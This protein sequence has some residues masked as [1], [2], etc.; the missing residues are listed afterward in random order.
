MKF[1][2]TSRRAFLKSLGLAIGGFALSSCGSGGSDGV[3]NGL[4]GNPILFPGGY[5][6]SRFVREGDHLPGGGVIADF[7][8]AVVIHDNSEVVFAAEDETGNQ[9][10]YR[11]YFDRAAFAPQRA[12][13]IRKVLRQGDVLPDGR[14]VERI[15]R[16]A[17]NLHHS[18]AVI[19]QTSHPTE[20]EELIGMQSRIYFSE[21]MG[22]FLPLLEPF[23][24]LP[25]GTGR[26]G[27]NFGDLDLH[28]N[29][30]LLVT[31][32]YSDDTAFPREGLFFI[33]GAHHPS[34]SKLFSNR[35]LVPDADGIIAGIGLIDL[36]DD[37]NFV[38]QVRTE[39]PA[40]LRG[41]G[42]GGN[43]P[44][45]VV[46]G[47]ARDLGSISLRGAPEGLDV[48]P[49]VR[50]RGGFLEGDSIYGPRVG[51]DGK[52]AQIV[53]LNDDDLVLAVGEQELFRAGGTV[54]SDEV[55]SM[56]GPVLG[57]NGLLYICLHSEERQDLVASDG[58]AFRTYL[59]QDD[60][61]DGLT[62]DSIGFGFMPKQVD[63]DGIMAFYG[64]FSDNTAAV[65]L[66]LPT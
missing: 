24:D 37:S 42:R 65:V 23:T 35:D 36:N 12:T 43:T 20:G 1:S 34:G 45:A 47:R 29:D 18:I 2:K 52:V 28:E 59:S 14:K 66:G 63:K 4:G 62:V 27:L 8:G 56:W 58:Q 53:H 26:F 25:D 3:G 57:R 33:P 21:A 17:A 22:P 64:D 30:D 5:I 16:F 13:D 6:F 49:A 41:R 50:S 39:T 60:E 40:S 55:S 11:A 51:R 48:S 31:A 38:C 19:L 32:N 54:S 10:I 15:G 46:A 7:T 44:T 9:G 61:I